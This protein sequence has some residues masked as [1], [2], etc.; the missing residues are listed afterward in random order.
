[1]TQTNAV[2]TIITWSKSQQQLIKD[3]RSAWHESL[4]KLRFRTGVWLTILIASAILYQS[5]QRVWEN[6]IYPVAEANGEVGDDG[7][8]CTII[9]GYFSSD[10]LDDLGFMHPSKCERT[11]AARATGL[12]CTGLSILAN[13]SS[14]CSLSFAH[15]SSA[16]N[17]VVVE[18]APE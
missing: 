5:S 4:Y 11:R 17:K 2:E 9:H 7:I 12:F 13:F 14:L 6:S 18:A 15:A 8:V 16:R 1:M 10:S 3:N